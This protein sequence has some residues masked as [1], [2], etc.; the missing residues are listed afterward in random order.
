MLSVIGPTG[1]SQPGKSAMFTAG[2]AVTGKELP[3]EYNWTVTGGKILAGQGTAT[4]EVEYPERGTLMATVEVNGFPEICPKV[5]SE[6]AAIDPAPEPIKIAH[7]DRRLSESD[8]ERL[9]SIIG[10]MQN[11]PNNHVYIFLDYVR[12]TSAEVMSRQE[13]KLFLD[14]TKA[15]IDG[16]RITFKKFMDGPD[17]VQFWRIPPGAENP[18]CE[19]CEKPKCPTRYR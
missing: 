6:F 12:G 9:Q 2:I 13:Q 19:E 1:V 11:H 10:E 14:L 4:I 16:G 15:G 18:M 3:L 5:A 7:F 8:F 17:I